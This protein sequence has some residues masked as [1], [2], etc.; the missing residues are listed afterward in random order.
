MD[1]EE[2]S[3]EEKLHVFA[4]FRDM[5]QVNHTINLESFYEH[6]HGLG[7]E[8]MRSANKTHPVLAST[9]KS[10][11]FPSHLV[12]GIPVSLIPYAI[13]M[14]DDVA[15]VDG[16]FSLLRKVGYGIWDGIVLPE[17]AKKTKKRRR[18]Q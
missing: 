7:D 17:P 8:V 18:K 11:P 9:M 2:M 14:V 16:V 3:P 15:G 10:A 6:A 4:A 12:G 5:L 13:E 1:T